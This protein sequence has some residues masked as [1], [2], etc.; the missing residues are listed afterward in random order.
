ML[1]V[2]LS[3]LKL[4]LA[5]KVHHEDVEGVCT[6]ELAVLDLRCHYSDQVLK[7]LI[8]VFPVAALK[9]CVHQCHKGIWLVHVQSQSF[10]VVLECLIEL[11][12]KL[13]DV[14]KGRPS[15]RTFWIYL[16][17]LRVLDEGLLYLRVCLE[18]VTLEF[19]CTLIVRV[20]RK[21]FFAYLHA[22]VLPAHFTF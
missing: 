16:H 18:K 6:G 3:N 15:T 12:F 2:E 21:D 5:L 11:A 17:S 9:L 4:L 14:A 13:E 22:V 8:I 20:H 10:L 7:V 1:R 19:V